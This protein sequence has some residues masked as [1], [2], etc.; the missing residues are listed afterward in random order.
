MQGL[1]YFSAD[2]NERL[3]CY[4]CLN[5]ALIVNKQRILYTKVVREDYTKILNI[6]S[7]N[8]I[9]PSKLGFSL[10]MVKWLNENIKN[11]GISSVFFD[12]QNQPVLKIPVKGKDENELKKFFFSFVYQI[13][14]S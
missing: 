12:K 1:I 8:D 6:E 4:K 13:S 5:C 10:D 7:N 3:N 9:Q 11:F 2:I 14:K